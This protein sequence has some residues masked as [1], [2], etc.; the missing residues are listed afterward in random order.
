MNDEIGETLPD[1]PSS[2][3]LSARDFNVEMSYVFVF[4]F[5]GGED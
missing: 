3:R 5:A 2:L 4:I 1:I